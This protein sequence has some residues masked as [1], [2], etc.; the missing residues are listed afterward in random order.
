MGRC[1]KQNLS[2][3]MA[4]TGS[5]QLETQMRFMERCDRAPGQKGGQ[6]RRASGGQAAA[7][8]GASEM[9]Q[10]HSV[11]LLRAWGA[12][13]WPIHTA[14]DLPAQQP[15]E[16]ATRH[17]AGESQGFSGER[18]ERSQA[19]EDAHCVVPPAGSSRTGGVRNQTSGCPP[20]PGD[21]SPRRAQGASRGYGNALV[22]T[23]A[24]A[25]VQS[26]QAACLKSLH[27]IVR[28]IFTSL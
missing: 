23:Q 7:S 25:L 8:R 24:C 13:M 3:Q 2:L 14:D 10:H 1:I 15:E 18:G 5:G 22:V 4:E 16:R 17:D 6:G 20:P 11:Q 28:G 26:H 19:P 9:H 27:V 12:N 21:G